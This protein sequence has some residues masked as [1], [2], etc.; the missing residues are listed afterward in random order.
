MQSK[1]IETQRP[2]RKYML[3][4]SVN[5]VQQS[6]GQLKKRESLIVSLIV[7]K[8]TGHSSSFNICSHRLCVY[9]T[10]VTEDLE[11]ILNI[12]EV[13][14]LSCWIPHMPD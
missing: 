9:S 12:P 14:I 3:A 7:W 10:F 6:V 8:S 1:M 11:S 5:D 13:Y 2:G 4:R